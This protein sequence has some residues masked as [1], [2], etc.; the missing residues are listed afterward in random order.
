MRKVTCS[1]CNG[2]GCKECNGTGKIIVQTG[3]VRGE[4]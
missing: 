1:S 3:P 2:K 4:R